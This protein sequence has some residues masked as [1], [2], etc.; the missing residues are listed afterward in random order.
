[1]FEY[2]TD[3]VID[4][5]VGAVFD[6][7][8]DL[9]SIPEWAPPVQEIRHVA[10]GDPEVG[11]EFDEIVGTPFGAVGVE[12]GA[13]DVTVLGDAAN[14]TAR[15]CSTAAAGEILVSE[16]AASSAGLP[17]SSLEKRELNLK[18]KREKVTVYV[19]AED[20]GYLSRQPSG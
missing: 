20:D 8:T 10:P 5:P 15:L 17:V 16:A 1:M 18:G 4:R 2:E 13:T 11:T 3:I 12:E 6:Y 9:N 19:L 7:I 14:T